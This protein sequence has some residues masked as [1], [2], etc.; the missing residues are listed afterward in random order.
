M[1]KPE[2]TGLRDFKFSHWIRKNLPDSRT[3]FL[4][5]DIDFVLFS[6]KTRS[7][8]LLEVKTKNFEF[9]QWQKNIFNLIDALLHRN[10]K[11]QG[12]NY[13]GFHV[14]TFTGEQCDFI[15]AECYFDKEQVSEDR[16]R[17][18]LSI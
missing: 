7:L 14:V 8:M 10:A 15:T 17:E 5:T 11:H 3:G 18:L 12:V 1:T 2:I 16:L 6:S 9:S 4:V 13:L